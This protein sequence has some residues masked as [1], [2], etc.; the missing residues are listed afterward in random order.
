M[1][2]RHGSDPAGRTEDDSQ[3]CGLRRGCH[4]PDTNCRCKLVEDGLLL[5]AVVAAQ[6][7]VTAMGETGGVSE[8]AELR[9]PLNSWLH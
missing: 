7:A 5:V 2:D 1:T 3:F 4:T 8:A 6:M 9:I